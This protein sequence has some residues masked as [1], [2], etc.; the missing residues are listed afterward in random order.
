MSMYSCLDRVVGLSVE[1]KRAHDVKQI[2][3]RMFFVGPPP[4]ES[5]D[6]G[7]ERV[8]RSKDY[9]CVVWSIRLPEGRASDP[10]YVET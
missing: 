10:E 5:P 8:W 2:V 6:R 1:Y 3:Y 9:V 4:L 7:I